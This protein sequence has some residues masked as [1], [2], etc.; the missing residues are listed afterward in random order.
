MWKKTVAIAMLVVVW[1]L[2]CYSQHGGR[3]GIG[4]VFGEPTGIAWKYHL[5]GVNSIDGGVGLSYLVKN[6]PID[7]FFEIAPLLVFAPG[8]GSGIDLGFGI[9]AYP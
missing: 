4:A 1:T 5:D 3:F 9:R 2:P 8:P 7:L 6:S